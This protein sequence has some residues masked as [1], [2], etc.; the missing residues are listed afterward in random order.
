MTIA[1][2]D[3]NFETLRVDRGHDRL[4]VTIDRPAVKNALNS[5]MNR[6]L[7]AVCAELEHEPRP[8]V[9]RGAGGAFVSGADIAELRERSSAETVAGA[10]ERLFDRVAR[11][12]MPT[13]AVVDGAAYGGG[14]ELAY[15]CDIRLASERA[16]F[17]NPEPALGIL[18]G[19]GGCW[20]LAELTNRS[21]ARQVLLGGLR[22]DASAALSCGLVAEVASSAQLEARVD[23]WIKRISAQDPWALQLTKLTLDAKDPHPVADLLAQALL[24]E[25]PERRRR[26]TEYLEGRGRT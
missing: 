22:L 15:A 13:I 17:A 3:G 7:N 24:F 4:T 19:A 14:A 18:A 6:E 26:M 25:A 11:L 10:N 1:E 21:V 2:N 16:A 8:L 23:A 20:R 5:R 9:L 12:P